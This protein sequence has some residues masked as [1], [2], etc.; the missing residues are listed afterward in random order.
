MAIGD[1]TTYAD[2]R[3]DLG[4]SEA[5]F[6]DEVAEEYFARSFRE[7]PNDTAKMIAN[8]RVLVIQGLLAGGI[9][10]SK[11]TQNQS[12]EDFTAIAGN[13]RWWLEY[14]QKKVAAAHDAATDITAGVFFKA[15]SGQRGR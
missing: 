7:Y 5:A 2:L 9:L 15:I 8:T 1:A 13:L 14:W 10:A 3:V 12:S 11:Y 6:P 4:V